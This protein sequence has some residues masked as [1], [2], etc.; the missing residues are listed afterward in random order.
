[1]QTQPSIQKAFNVLERLSADDE[2][3]YLAQ[4]REES[5][6]FE[7]IALASQKRKVQRDVAEKLLQLGTM[8]LEQIAEISGL[9]FDQLQEIADEKLHHA[10][11][12]Q[13]EAAKF[14]SIALAAAEKK[15]RTEGRAEGEV[16]GEIRM[17]QRMLKLPVN[18]VEELSQK[19]FEE[20][21]VLLQEL[22]IQLHKSFHQ[23]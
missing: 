6:K 14:E 18:S 19:S 9:P 4:K 2:T 20:L 5:L 23:A 12:V 7:K 22:E 13:K 16:M 3:R 21:Q 10:V 11:D 1:M 17:A 15:V 8:S